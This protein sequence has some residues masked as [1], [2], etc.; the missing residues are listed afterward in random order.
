[1]AADNK[2]LGRFQLV[3]HC[4]VLFVY[5]NVTRIFLHVQYT[6]MFMIIQCGGTESILMFSLTIATTFS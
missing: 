3:C 2:T 4:I 1:M 6:C 5:E